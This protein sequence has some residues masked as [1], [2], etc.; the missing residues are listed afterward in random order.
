MRRLLGL[1]GFLFV[2]VFILAMQQ[3]CSDYPVQNQFPEIV[4]SSNDSREYR[5]IR[6]EN[7]LDVLLIS[8]PSTDKAAASLDV[9]IGSY[10][11]QLIGQGWYIF[12]SICCF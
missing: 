7:Q 8:D 11:I 1:S 10:K 2:A 5:H 9:N 6:L 3:G 4:V 12:L